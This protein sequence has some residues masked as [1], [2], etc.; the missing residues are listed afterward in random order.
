M[1]DEPQ[2]I[3]SCIECRT[4]IPVGARVCQHCTSYQKKWKNDLRYA[5]TIVR[6]LGAAAALLVYLIATLP[7][8][9]KRMEALSF[10]AIGMLLVGRTQFCNT[11]TKSR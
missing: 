8:V 10:P 9:T 7:Q 2:E 5:S 6:V 4:P 3:Q 11:L 1:T